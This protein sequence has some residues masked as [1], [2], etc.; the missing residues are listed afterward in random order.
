MLQRFTRGDA[1][2]DTTLKALAHLMDSQFSVPIL[3]WRFGLNTLLDLIPG[4]GDAATSVV[5]ILIMVAAGRRGASRATLLRMGFNIAVYAV[6]GVLPLI[7]DVFDSWWK[8]NQRN[9][10]MLS[11]SAEEA[12]RADALFLGALATALALLVLLCLAL[13]LGILHY[14]LK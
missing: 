14:L 11:Q 5:A 6:G 12:H 2:K 3:G 7:G 8:P 4:L 1:D 10:H 9:L 13:F